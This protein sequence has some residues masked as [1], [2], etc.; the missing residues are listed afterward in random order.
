M[1]M[2][3]FGL[4]HLVSLF[5]YPSG[6]SVTTIWQRR[7][8]SLGISLETYTFAF[9]NH[10]CSVYIKLPFYWTFQK[11]SDKIAYHQHGRFYI[12]STSI[13]A[14]KRDFNRMAKLKQTLSDSAVHVE[15][16]IRYWASTP[17]DFE[18]FSTIVLRTTTLYQDAWI[19]EHLLISKWQAPLNFPFITEILKLKAKGWQL[20]YRRR[21]Q[22][23]P[24]VPLGDRLYRRVRRKLHSLQCFISESSFQFT[25]WTILYRL[26]APGRI[27]YDTAASLRSGKFHDWEL[28]SFYRLAAHL[29]EPL[30]SQARH[31]MKQAFTFR[32]LTKPH[33]FSFQYTFLG[34][35]LFQSEYYKV[36]TKP[37]T[38][39]Q[40]GGHTTTP[41]Y[42]QATRSCFS[43]DSAT[44][45]QSQTSRNLVGS[46]QR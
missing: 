28:Y 2:W 31:K 16:A 44:S 34:T 41:T 20:Q 3:S 46:R 5:G 1:A 43:H 10:A 27:A 42:S 6:T 7:L 40:G 39:T 11:F 4:L 36:A 8:S 30:R 38:S 14:A 32:N 12:G 26:T 33:E 13:T 17:S 15:L 18:Q 35:F 9:F 21:N 29:E 37:C 19:Y 24:R 23:F 25:A 45:S 22:Q